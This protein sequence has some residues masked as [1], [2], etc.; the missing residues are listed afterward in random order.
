MIKVESLHEKYANTYIVSN[1][2]DILI[3]DPAIDERSIE[4]MIRRYF[5][6]QKVV[7]IILTHGHYDHFKTLKEVYQKYKVPVYISKNDY[8]KIND[9]VLSC[10]NLFGILKS[11]SFDYPVTYLQEGNIEI[12]SFKLKIMFTPG[13]TN[14]SVCIIMEEK[15]FSGDTLFLDGVGRTDLPTGNVVMLNNSIEKLMNLKTDYQ[16]FPGHGDSTTI[17]LER[18]YNY[19]YQKIKK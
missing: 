5:E 1:D 13:H 15:L 14:G 18:K 11:D 8:P 17:D 7:G 16:V 19:Y 12:G 4:Q 9:V 2:H 10:A 3:I 6:N